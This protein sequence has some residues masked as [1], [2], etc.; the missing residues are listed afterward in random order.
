MP[1]SSQDPPLVTLAYSL[2]PD[3]FKSLRLASPDIRQQLRATDTLGLTSLVTSYHD[4]LKGAHAM[5]LRM[6]PASVERASFTCRLKWKVDGKT[7]TI[8]GK[9]EMT[10]NY[11]FLILPTQRLHGPPI[12]KVQ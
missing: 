11:C 6:V 2:S 8:H 5:E 9:Y 3:E 4:D 12:T 7:E 1:S 10:F